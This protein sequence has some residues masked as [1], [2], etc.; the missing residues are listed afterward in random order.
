M[1]NEEEKEILMEKIITETDDI[2]MKFLKKTE[3]DLGRAETLAIL[4]TLATKI[5]ACVKSCTLNE[6]YEVLIEE[7]LKEVGSNTEKWI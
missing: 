7:L 3:K 6:D 2:L 4:M 1:M 5:L